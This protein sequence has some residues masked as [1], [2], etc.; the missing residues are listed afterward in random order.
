MI[1]HTQHITSCK[2]SSH[3]LHSPIEAIS[4]KRKV[5]LGGNQETNQVE[6]FYFDSL[7]GELDFDFSS[8]EFAF[9]PSKLLA[10]LALQGVGDSW[11]GSGM[12]RGQLLFFE[13]G[14]QVCVCV[15]AR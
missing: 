12:Q 6:H 2:G 15:C 11:R 7:G 13:S 8:T 5:P 1:H 14:M 3:S 4:P 10:A 9:P